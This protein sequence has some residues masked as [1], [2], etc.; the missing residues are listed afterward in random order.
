MGRELG[1]RVLGG[2]VGYT[3]RGTLNQVSP[4]TQAPESGFDVGS[5]RSFSPKYLTVF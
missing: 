2:E 3:F 1:S 4:G 5:I